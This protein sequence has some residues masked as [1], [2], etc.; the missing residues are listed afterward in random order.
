M[1]CTALKANAATTAQHNTSSTTVPL[2][3]PHL[4]SNKSRHLSRMAQNLQARA[5]TVSV[6]KIAHTKKHARN[7]DVSKTT[8]GR[9]PRPRQGRCPANK[10]PPAH[11]RN[12]RQDTPS[13]DP[14]LV[15]TQK[16]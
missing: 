3:Q 6:E 2:Q 11:Q 10:D 4:D 12:A 1:W 14:A 9:Q 15:Q 7:G 8:A 5:I 13:T 16:P